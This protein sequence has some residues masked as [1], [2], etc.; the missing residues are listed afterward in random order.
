MGSCC[1]GDVDV[2]GYRRWIWKIERGITR[3]CCSSLNVRSSCIKS[4][5]IQGL[6]DSY[7]PV[8]YEW[9]ER[10]TCL[11]YPG[12]ARI[13]TSSML[14][15]SLARAH[16]LERLLLFSL[17]SSISCLDRPLLALRT[18]ETTWERVFS[19][20]EHTWTGAPTRLDQFLHPHEQE[21]ADFWVQ[22]IA[23]SAWERD[24]VAFWLLQILAVGETYC[25]D[26]LK[27]GSIQSWHEW[28]H[29]ALS[30]A[31]L[32]GFIIKLF[33]RIPRQCCCRSEL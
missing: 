20:I 18:T 17:E 27:L 13:I 15:W 4:V 1:C 28:D 32:T 22:L 30:S 7:H 23:K 33:D 3:C 8:W 11:E 2:E 14:T 19:M 10:I 5:G 31:T 29:I 9:L 24:E 16:F 25:N 21:S 6:N 12:Y 26:N